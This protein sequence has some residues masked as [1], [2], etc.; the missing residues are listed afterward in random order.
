MTKTNRQLMNMQ[1]TFSFLIIMT[2]LSCK[3]Q[4]D[5]KTHTYEKEVEKLK[6]ENKH[7]ISENNL[8]KNINDSLK[9]EL[10]YLLTDIEKINNEL[11]IISRRFT[12]IKYLT[13]SDFQYIKNQKDDIY[14]ENYR[15]EINQA[16]IYRSVYISRIE[17]FNEGLQ[18]ITSRE[19]L[20]IDNLSEIIPEDTSSL[21]FI[22]WI[23]FNKFI[24]NIRDRNFVVKI[25]NPKTFTITEK[26]I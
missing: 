6:I 17:Y 4:T 16:E 26:N 14:G 22:K 7:L 25:L 13:S 10:D 20:N 19:K 9:N 11:K 18:R 8:F 15:V 21:E 23:D 5:E 24:I 12:T 1:K 3:P 2:F